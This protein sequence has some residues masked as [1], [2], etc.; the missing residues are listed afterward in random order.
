MLKWTVSLL[1][2]V[3]NMPGPHGLGLTSTNVTKPEY[4]Q[5]FTPSAPAPSVITP[6]LAETVIPGGGLDV[7]LV[8]AA[9]VLH[10]PGTFG[11]LIEP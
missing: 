7:E 10:P 2:D 3:H 8:V 9:P 5:Y 4:W 6:P 1:L 11:V